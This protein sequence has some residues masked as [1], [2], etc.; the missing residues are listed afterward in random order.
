[1]TANISIIATTTFVILFGWAVGWK[2][3]GG[4]FKD[5][6]TKRDR[7]LLVVLILF[8]LAALIYTFFATNG[9]FVWN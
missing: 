5:N 6:T 2:L 8:V 4:W 9:T 1:V 3:F 7:T